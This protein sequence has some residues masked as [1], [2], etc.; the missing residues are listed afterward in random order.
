M[1]KKIF[2]ANWKSNKSI[3]ESKDFFEEINSKKSE[4]DFGSN[5]IIISPPFPLL[6][7]CKEQIEKYGLPF[8][9]CAQDVSQ[10]PKGAYTG[11]VNAVLINQ[12]A[13]YAIIGHSERRTYFKEDDGILEKKVLQALENNL[14]PIYCVQNENQKVPSGVSL[15]AFEPPTAIGSGKPDDVLDIERVFDILIS[16]NPSIK[17]LYGG[18]V[19]SEN[20]SD[21]VN[22]KNISGFLI[23]GASL[24]ADSFL[25]L[26]EN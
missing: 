15:V 25:S 4:L 19:N 16:K 2:I 18:S 9:L 10:F 11:E 26:L 5:T 6:S 13:N 14:I 22:I 3:E 17:V 8:E 24:L 21:F 20:I 23:G 12:F 7:V 1:E